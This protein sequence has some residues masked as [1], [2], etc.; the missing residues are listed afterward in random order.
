MSPKPMARAAPG[1]D[2]ASINTMGYGPR[3]I[4]CSKIIKR[5][6]SLGM[7][8]FGESVH[9]HRTKDSYGANAMRQNMPLKSEELQEFDVVHACS[10]F[11]LTGMIPKVPPGA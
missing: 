8:E 5:P 9:A 6:K 2:M 7:R 3:D 11:L 4:V 10:E 1:N